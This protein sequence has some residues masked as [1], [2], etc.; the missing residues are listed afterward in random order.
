MIAFKFLRAG[1]IG[2]FSESE[3]PDAGRWLEAEGP[4]LACVNGVHACA[5]DTLAYWFDDELW[6]VELG[7]EIL[8]LDTVLVGQRGRLL[9]RV[10]A[11]PDGS[12]AFAEDC[13]AQ[14]GALSRRAPRNARVEGLAAETAEHAA[15]AVVPR[16]AVLAAYATA[17]AADIVEPGGFDAERSRQSRRLAELLRL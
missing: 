13:A 7:G 16:H 1:S 14:A 5:V 11:W 17:V 10:D 9:S 2:R 15:Q 12:L 6:N 8:D 3:W 4:L